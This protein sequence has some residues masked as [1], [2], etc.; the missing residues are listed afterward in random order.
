MKKEIYCL[1]IAAVCFFMTA[2]SSSKQLAQYPEEKLDWKLGAQ[3][4]TFRL[5]SFAEALD[6]IQASDLRFVEAFPGQTIGAGNEETFTYDLSAEGRE[7][8]KQLLKE[9]GITLHAYGVVGAKDAQEWE[10]VFAFAK[11]M[12]VK[13]ITCEPEEEHLDIVSA[14]CDKYDIQA[15]IHNHPNPSHYWNPDVL[16]KALEGRSPRMGAAVDVGHWMRSGL[17]PVECLKK[18][19]GHILHSHFKDLNAFGDKKST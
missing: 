18:L 4:Y 8:V 19:E 7:M 15:A 3:A 16:L 2:C 13:V 9:K 1:L 12:G 17:D 14:L 10:K 5:F 11:D 6:K